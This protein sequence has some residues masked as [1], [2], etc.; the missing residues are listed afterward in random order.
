M[1]LPC[2][3]IIL[4]HFFC[5]SFLTFDDN[6]KREL[7]CTRIVYPK[8]KSAKISSKVVWSSSL[9]AKRIL[10]LI[11]WCPNS[12]W[13][14]IS[15]LIVNPINFSFTATSSWDNLFRRRKAFKLEPIEISWLITNDISI[16]LP[17]FLEISSFQQWY[18]HYEK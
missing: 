5:C 16:F 10:T 12:I 7:L 4:H 1:S 9:R 17:D 18:G 14:T 2:C 3:Y 13:E 8:D 15:R 6:P 11:L